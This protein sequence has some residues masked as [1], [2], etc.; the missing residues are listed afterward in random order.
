MLGFEENWIQNERTKRLI[1]TAPRTDGKQERSLLFALLERAVLDAAGQRLNCQE[2][3]STS[4]NTIRDAREWL[5]DWEEGDFH[6]PYSFC[7][8]CEHLDLCPQL[9]RDGLRAALSE[10]GKLRKTHV[11]INGIMDRFLDPVPSVGD[12]NLY[13][14]YLGD[15]LLFGDKKK[16]G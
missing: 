9:V 4:E 13:Y 1:N 14:S 15:T 6:E 3:E 2:G 16:N 12:S 10:D 11:G 8:V 5:L 7:W